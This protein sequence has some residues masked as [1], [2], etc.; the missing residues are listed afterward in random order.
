ML[1]NMVVATAI[2]LIASAITAFAIPV[3]L[4]D[5]IWLALYMVTVP[6]AI[7]AVAARGRQLEFYATT[8][9]ILVLISALIF[10]GAEAASGYMELSGSLLFLA[11][12]PVTVVVGLTGAIFV[13]LARWKMQPAA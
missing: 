3:V 4:D 2:A 5:W 8:A 7:A 6:T 13:G 1:M 12:F 9:T 11:T 10:S